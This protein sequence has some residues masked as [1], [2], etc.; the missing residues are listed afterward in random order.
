MYAV[1][2]YGFNPAMHKGNDPLHDTERQATDKRMW[3]GQN[4]SRQSSEKQESLDEGSNS[5][6]YLC[7]ETI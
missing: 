3:W 6:T 2:L 4:P 5:V 7:D 1:R